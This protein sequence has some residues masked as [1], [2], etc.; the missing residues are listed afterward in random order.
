MH[1]LRRSPAAVRSRYALIVGLAGLWLCVACAQER[2]PE[3][4]SGWTD[5]R[6]VESRHFMVA[7][8]N[9]VAV[10]AGY[11]VVVRE[12]ICDTYRR[13]RVCG[14]PLPSS[15]GLA[16]LQILKIL[17]PY[18]MTT[19]IEFAFGSK[20]MTKSGFLLNNEL[21]DFSFV[22]FEDGKVVAN[23]MEAGKRPRSSLAPTVVYDS[24]GRIYML[25]GSP[26]GSAI[27]NYAAKTFIG[28]LDWHLDPQ[29]GD[30]ATQRRQ[31]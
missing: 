16:V 20:L 9:P 12:P 24:A 22:P 8:A 3:H 23:R 4:P 10:D 15:G 25:A 30:R 2:A 21:T 13:Y 29:A 5:K 28:V 1:L 7:A 17:E 26:G 31:P 11:R 6:P 18:E 27:I 19:T 14:M